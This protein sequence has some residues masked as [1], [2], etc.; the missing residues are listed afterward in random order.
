MCTSQSAITCGTKIVHRTID[1]QRGYENLS[2]LVFKYYVDPHVWTYD[3]MEAYEPSELGIGVQ[4]PLSPFG[5][6][7]SNNI[8][9]YRSTYF[10]CFFCICGVMVAYGPSKARMGVQFPPNAFEIILEIIS[11]Q[12]S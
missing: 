10:K 3:V 7:K 11:F 2:Y 8:N 12:I 1:L 5:Y 6:W 9:S 4:L